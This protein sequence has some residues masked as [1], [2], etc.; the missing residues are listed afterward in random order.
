MGVCFSNIQRIPDI[1]WVFRIASHSCMFKVSICV[2]CNTYAVSSSE[3]FASASDVLFVFWISWSSYVYY[4]FLACCVTIHPVQNSLVIYK[5]LGC[6][7]ILDVIGSPRSI[8]RSHIFALVVS[9][10]SYLRFSGCLCNTL[11]AHIRSFYVSLVSRGLFITCGFSVSFVS[12]VCW[13]LGVCR[14]TQD[15][16]H[17]HK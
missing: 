6:L 15:C 16:F 8:S 1:S 7:G 9:V 3:V 4:I 5:L 12:Q 17:L 11:F 14:P 13:A 2:F 10:P